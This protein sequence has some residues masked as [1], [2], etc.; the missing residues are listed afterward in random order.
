MGISE[1]GRLAGK[2]A[3][4]TG[5]GE[6][7]VVVAG[8]TDTKIKGTAQLVERRLLPAISVLLGLFVAGSCEA[9]SVS[10]DANAADT[11]SVTRKE[12]RMWMIIGERRFAITLADK[13]SRACVHRSTAI[14]I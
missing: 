9:Q 11:A 6:A 13:C 1:N 10:P 5:G 7:S 8:R 14:D 12:L 4:V 2:V 3:F